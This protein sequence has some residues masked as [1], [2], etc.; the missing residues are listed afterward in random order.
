MTAPFSGPCEH[1]GLTPK[2]DWLA[3]C[4]YADTLPMDRREDWRRSGGD[5]PCAFD[6]DDLDHA[7][8]RKSALRHIAVMVIL[9]LGFVL[10][11]WLM[12]G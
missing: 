5:A 12:L 6:A 8:L 4:R 3:H 1:C 7:E 9:S 2:S 10:T 11:T